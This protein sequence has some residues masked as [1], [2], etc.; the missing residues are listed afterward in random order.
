MKKK[1]NVILDFGDIR[2]YVGKLFYSDK[3]GR[4]AF[5]YN[6]EFL[7]SGIE[8]SPKEM[9]LGRDTYTFQRDKDQYD[10]HGV[11][12]DSLPDAW[13]KLVQDVEF[14]KIGMH[15]VSTIDRLAFVGKYGIGAL[16]YEPSKEFDR[17]SE[18]VSLAELRKAMQGIFAGDIEKVT[19]ELLRL[20]GSAG[21][22][23]PKF[24]VD[25]NRENLSEIRYSGED[26]SENMIPILLKMP[27]KDD[28]WQRIEYSYS[29]IAKM[30]GII[31]PET[32]L[33]FSRNGNAHFA[34]Q[35]F[36]VFQDGQ[37]LH[38]HSYAGIDGFSFRHDDRDYI[39]FLRMVNVLCRKHSDV[40][41]GYRRMVF[42][43]L[44]GN[45]DDHGKNFCFTMDK[46]G[47]WSLSPAFDIAYSDN[48]GLH[49]MS[50]NGKR[51][52]LQVQDLEHTAK[53]FE[54]KNWK[55][56]T[57]QIID[58][59]EKWQSLAIELKIPGGMINKISEHIS[60]NVNRIRKGLN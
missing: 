15:E 10:I 21:G 40:V 51:S 43:Y 8:I 47:I 38:T 39:D 5:S 58:A 20:G 34:I 35:R 33:L 42:N 53:K 49:R 44:G 32:F 56:V 13:G 1:L 48:G 23:H 17:G 14:Q 3:M 30:A 7:G 60:R 6:E 28:F 50:V 52:S 46:H 26:V 55:D 37:R 24:L 4:Y 29:K 59:L 57:L 36:D 16:R 19:S 22:A 27:K 12:A 9:P 18:I 54:I 11:F 2:H 25:L 41:E 45:Q 31:I